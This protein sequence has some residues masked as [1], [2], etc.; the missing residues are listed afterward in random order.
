MPC[1]FC[2]GTR[3]FE[4]AANLDARFLD[5]GAVW[6]F[7]FAA[8]ALALAAALVLRGVAPGRLDAVVVRARAVS[9]RVW[10]AGLGALIAVAWVW[11]LAHTATI[12]D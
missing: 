7:A 1:P 10:F 4:H 2:G 9:A 6:V 3:A 11:A 8:V 5:Y 12:A